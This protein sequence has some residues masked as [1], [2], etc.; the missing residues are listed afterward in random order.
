MRNTIQCVR[1]DDNTLRNDPLAIAVVFA[2]TGDGVQ[3]LTGNVGEICLARVLVLKLNQ[4]A[5]TT[6]IAER[7]PLAGCHH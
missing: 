6:A 3:L 7:L 4:T 5:F 1:L 2:L